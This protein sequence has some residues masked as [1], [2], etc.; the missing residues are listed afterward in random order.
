MRAR[1]NSTRMALIRLATFAVAALAVSGCG[2]RGRSATDWPLPNGD[3]SSTRAASGSGIDR[4]SVARLKLAWRFRFRVPPGE[5]GTFTATPVVADG[6]V[7]LQDMKSNVFA[8]DLETGSV[9]WRR[10]FNDTNPG[11]NGLAV[12]GGRVYGATDT[13]VFALST[14]TG[15]TLW[16]RRLLTPVEQYVDVAP[17]VA[18]GVVYMS[19]IGLPPGGKGA[20]YALD[21]RTG[22]VRWKF[23]TIKRAWRFPQTAGGGGAWFPPSLVDGTLYW[24]TANPYPYGGT[25][26]YPNGSSFPGPALYTDSLLALDARRGA[27]LWYDQVTPHDVRDYDF[28]IPPIIGTAG[29]R[30]A[31][32]GAG[33]AGIVIA[34]DRTTHARLWQVEVGVHRND[35]GPLPRRPMSV[36]PGLLGGVETPMAYAAETLFVPV[37]DLCARG[38]RYGYEPLDKIDV[39]GRGRGELVA[40]A[41][42]N[43]RR[44][45]MRRFE[46]PV[47]GCATV[48]NDVV[49]TST[50]DGR[51]Y[52]LDTRNGDIVWRMSLPAGINACPS[53]AG[54]HLLV[55]AGV[56]RRGARALELLA[57][58]VR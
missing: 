7:F 6:A 44:R 13:T 15:R 55:G 37:V 9:R 56:P 36:C 39:S 51:V 42:A 45:W 35:H 18:S 40:L 2:T 34:W 21:A 32:F 22:A 11:P 30:R 58:V 28:A 46:Q 31:V 12:A 23:S 5:S 53:I 3:L 41:A 25:R 43:G 10:L 14:A 38:S 27:L 29:S 1:T 19:T 52:G 50:F 54:S 17:L 8:L 16:S 57:F 24:G 48:A 49:F 4:G 26:R 47:F 33:K 20:L